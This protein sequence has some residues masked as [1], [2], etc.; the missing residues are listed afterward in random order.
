M[1]WR[2]GD[3]SR[4]RE[5]RKLEG[6][7]DRRPGGLGR[8]R[9]RLDSTVFTMPLDPYLGLLVHSKA[10]A[11]VTAVSSPAD[12]VTVMASPQFRH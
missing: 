10:G 1:V 11:T 2:A 12:I 7:A 4:T 5:G 6:K 8:L 3:E 9:V